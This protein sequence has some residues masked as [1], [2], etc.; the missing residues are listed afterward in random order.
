MTGDRRSGR[1]ASATAIGEGAAL[2]G[3]APR[4]Q[5]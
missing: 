2:A 1:T 3:R 5:L 4:K